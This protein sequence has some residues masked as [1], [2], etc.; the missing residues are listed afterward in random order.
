MSVL[1]MVQH[2]KGNLDG[3]S[4]QNHPSSRGLIVIQKRG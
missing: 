1:C 3:L 2:R 4:P